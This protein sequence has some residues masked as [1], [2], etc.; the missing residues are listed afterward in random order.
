MITRSPV[1]GVLA[2]A[3]ALFV[4]ACGGSIASPTTTCTYGGKS[5][6]PGQSFPDA[7]GCN[8][9][10]C[11]ADGTIACTAMGCV[12]PCEYGGKQYAPGQTFPALDGCNTCTCA[13]DG[14]GVACTEKACVSC[15]YGGTTY[16]PGDTFA[17][18][19]GC[20][21]C[22]CLQAG[23]VAC[24]D[25]ACSSCTY[26]GKTYKLGDT[27]PATDGC[28]TCTCAADGSG[29][30]C[31]KKACLC[32]PS[33]EWYRKYVGT[34]PAQCAVID[35]V[36]PANTTYFANDCGCGCQQGASCPQWFDCMPPKPCDPVQIKADCP[37]SG[38]AY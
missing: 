9:C 33:K 13:T 25:R 2:V 10:S 38:I 34:S 26:A 27:F 24:T 23:D 29:V 30:A 21:T 19:D 36:C 1:R 35:F 11:S 3:L 6:E 16:K 31:T 5:Y 4:I 12:K 37:Y 20:N 32:D 7:D 8:T 14:S 22:T 15:V 28:N 18:V 17:D